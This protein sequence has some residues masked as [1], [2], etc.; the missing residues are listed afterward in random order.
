M[1]KKIDTED[2]EVIAKK[3]IASDDEF[4][5][6]SDIDFND[7]DG[8]LL[9][10]D[11]E[12]RGSL[13]PEG[14][15]IDE[16]KGAIKNGEI[17]KFAQIEPNEMETFLQKP[18]IQN[19]VDG[20]VAIDGAKAKETPSAKGFLEEFISDMKSALKGEDDYWQSEIEEQ[21]KKAKEKSVC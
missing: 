2:F 18:S 20:K 15:K 14:I 6:V 7:E 10:N 4:S 1:V 5:V 21:R 19:L 17:K 3:E 13:D 8:F 16:K 11:N 12:K 9:V